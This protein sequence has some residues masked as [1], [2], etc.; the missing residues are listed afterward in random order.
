MKLRAAVTA[1]RSNGGFKPG[2]K[3]KGLLAG[4]VLTKQPP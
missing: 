4:S 2:R 1:S 3:V